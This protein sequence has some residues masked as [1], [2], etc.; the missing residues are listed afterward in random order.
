MNYTVVWRRRAEA[1]L[2]TIWIRSANKDA[3][4]GYGN[5]IERVLGRDPRDQGEARANGFR[6]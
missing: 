5:Q 6:L 3:V 1:Q 4:A 2:T